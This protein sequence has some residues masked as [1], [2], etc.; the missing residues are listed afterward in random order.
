MLS[1][2][3][4]MDFF[5]SGFYIMRR[6][7]LFMKNQSLKLFWEFEFFYNIGQAI[8]AAKF[9]IADCDYIKT[10]LSL[11]KCEIIKISIFMNK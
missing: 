10:V 3:R 8:G 1:C 9:T 4:K 11:D 7:V 2:E 5:C 6:K